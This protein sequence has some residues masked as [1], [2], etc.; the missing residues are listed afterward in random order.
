MQLGT[1]PCH[2]FS[3]ASLA[4]RVT[5]HYDVLRIAGDWKLERIGRFFFDPLE[6]VCLC[7]EPLY[8]ASM[9]EWR[10]GSFTTRTT[11]SIEF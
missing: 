11:L 2:N 4:Q 10:A 7:A 6:H 9:Q 3:T 1:Q 5:G 8:P